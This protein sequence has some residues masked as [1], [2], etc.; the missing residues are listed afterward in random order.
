MSGLT[1]N[2]ENALDRFEYNLSSM[3]FEDA[4][5]QLSQ[6]IFNIR[7]DNVRRMIAE[8]KAPTK[9]DGE[10]IKA[11]QSEFNE[12]SKMYQQM[13]KDGRLVAVTPNK[14]FGEQLLDTVKKK[15]T[16]IGEVVRMLPKDQKE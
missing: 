6:E 2:I 8:R 16:V 14:N 10:L 15:K 7:L 13:K 11:V 3:S 5:D 12:M 1:D 9:E 4:Y